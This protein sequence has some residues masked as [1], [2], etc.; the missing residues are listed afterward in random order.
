MPYSTCS[1]PSCE[2]RVE[3]RGWCSTHYQRWQRHGDPLGGKHYKPRKVR[4]PAPC[5]V[6]GCEKVKRTKGL[7]TTHYARLLR[8][9][10]TGTAELR[11]KPFVEGMT[12]KACTK[13]GETKP[14]SE[15]HRVNRPSQ[16]VSK[17]KP[18]VAVITAKH[19]RKRLYGLNDAE[20]V[21]MVEAQGGGCFVCGGT[22]RLCVDHDHSTGKVRKLL[23]DMCNKALGMVEDSP[24]RLRGLAVY[25]ETH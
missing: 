23:C 19:Q 15:F 14:L 4:L 3:G 2:L 9:G 8:H 10:E 16:Y 25:L 1:I 21:A 13:C 17:C 12:E 20:Y 6:D 18:C 24:Q 5:S 11:C 22:D 7:C